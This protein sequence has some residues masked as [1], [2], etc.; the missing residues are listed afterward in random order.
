M[1]ERDFKQYQICA[2]KRN[3]RKH[4]YRIGPSDLPTALVK[5]QGKLNDLM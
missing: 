5:E 3:K 4:K 2:C 1:S